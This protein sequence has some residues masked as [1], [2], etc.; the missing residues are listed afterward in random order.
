MLKRTLKISL[1]TLFI[2]LPVFQSHAADNPLVGMI[3]QQLGVSQDQATGG[4]GALLSSAQQGMSGDDFAALTDVIPDMSSLLSAAPSLEGA[5][6]GGG[7]LASMATDML[8]DSA[9]SDTIALTQAFES[10]GLDSSMVGQYSKILLDF[11]NSEG[12][13]ALMQSLKSALL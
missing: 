3:T 13:N 7:G 12:G 8:G 10:L 2:L 5:A 11:V 1:F 9:G 4:L 6:G